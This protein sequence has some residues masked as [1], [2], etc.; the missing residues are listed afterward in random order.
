MTTARRADAQLGELEF[1]TANGCGQRRRA[2]STP[3]PA[4]RSPKRRASGLDFKA[5]VE[6]APHRRRPDAA[7]DDVP[8]ARA[9][10]SR[11]W[12]STS[13]RGRTSSTRV[14][15]A[16]GATKARL[17]DRHRRRHRDVLRLRE[18]RPARVS[19]TRRSTSTAAAEALSKGGTF[20]GR[21]ICVP[22]EG[23]AVHINAFNFP[24]WGMLEKL[25]P[26]LLAGMPA[27]VK[28]ATV[29]SYLTE[30]CCAAMIES[31][32][33]PTGAIQLIVR[34]RR[35]S[36]RSPRRARTPWRSPARRRRAQMLKSVK[37]ILEHN[38]RFNRKRTR[39]TT[40]CSAP[41]RRRAREEFDLFVKEVV[42]EMTAKAGQKCTAIRRTLV[43]DGDGGRRDR[44][45][46]RSGSPA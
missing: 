46:S 27:I 43:P 10:C 8:R 31:G 5:M 18:P 6:Y 15:A 25:A 16:T 12:R 7:R 34:Q 45:R 19:R 2:L 37:A 32:L 3:S 33:F 4:R 17:V 24:V 36:A 39:S 44:A 11:R 38:V 41:T 42:R 21:H 9:A 23:V 28:P 29:T 40:R 22:L 30:A 20:V 14:S 35:R 26:T 1:A 13:W